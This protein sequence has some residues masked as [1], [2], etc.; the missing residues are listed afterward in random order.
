MRHCEVDHSVFSRLSDRGRVIL[1]VYV[2]DIIITGNNCT[3]IKEL[4]TSL[5]TQLHTKDLEKLRYFLGIEVA[6]SKEGISMS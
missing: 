3:G 6:R 2:Y 5:Q 1:I 4:K